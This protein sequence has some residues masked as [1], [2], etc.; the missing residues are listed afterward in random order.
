MGQGVK[1]VST[2]NILMS[3][4]KATLSIF[5]TIPVNMVKSVFLPFHIAGKGRVGVQI[6]LAMSL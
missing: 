1:K 2:A 3:F 5:C 4:V 6:P